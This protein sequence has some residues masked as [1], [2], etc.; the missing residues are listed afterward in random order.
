MSWVSSLFGKAR[1]PEPTVEAQVAETV[2]KNEGTREKLQERYDDQ[3]EF[4]RQLGENV[5]R[6]N[7][8]GH[9]QQAM[10]AFKEMQRKQ[11]AQALL[12]VR[13]RGLFFY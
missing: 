1:P 4:I 7:V 3:E 2:D 5:K 6:L 13:N 12:Q 10:R 9:K 8:N 11:K